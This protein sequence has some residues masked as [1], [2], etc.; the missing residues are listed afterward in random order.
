M[1][2][3]LCGKSCSSCVILESCSGCSLCE[4]SICSHNC[5][6][7]YA[8]CPERPQ[9]AAHLNSLGGP[10]IN[11][12]ENKYINLPVHIPILPDRMKVKPRYE[13]LPVIA[14]HAGNAFSRNGEKIN[15]SYTSNGIP[16]ALNL[17]DMTSAILEFYVKDRTIEG[18]WD[19]RKDIYP[20]LRD[21]QFKAVISPNFSVYE[22]APR[23]DHLY[24]IKRSTI[25]YNEM[26]DA[27]IDAIPDVSWFNKTD[28]DRWCNEID[29]N[30]IK[31]VSFSF[32][33]VDV[34]LKTTNIWKSCLMGF[35]YFCH[36]ISSNV[37]VIIA[38]L[39][40]PYRV[41]EVMKAANGNRIHILNQSA[42]VQSRRGMLSETREQNRKMS[43]DQLF[44]RNIEYFNRVY[45]EMGQ[46]T[47]NNTFS[48][49]T[50]WDTGKLIEFYNDYTS[51]TEGLDEKYGM[52]STK[53][54]LAF[55][56]VKR[57]LKK[58]KQMKHFELKGE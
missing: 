9:A 34:G 26:L 5:N 30:N 33:V 2:N 15:K 44:E 12:Q 4:A 8:L 35:R 45:G 14:V 13:L 28:L 36:N 37:R 3:S 49:I 54:D 10:Q 55:S 47:L 32:Q 22:D 48:K 58:K 43:F 52:E 18:F 25:V 57:Q 6:S 16:G 19:K 50:S 1:I 20:V 21:L 23:I 42:Y 27:G 53:I 41:I 38:G 56:I 11:L 40:S 31:I 39:V 29:R 7:C 46:S 51:S 17:D 24:N